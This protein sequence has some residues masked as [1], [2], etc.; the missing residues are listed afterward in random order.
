MSLAICFASG[1]LDRAPELLRV[2]INSH[3][4]D[5]EGSD[6]DRHDGYPRSPIMIM[7]LL[8]MIIMKVHTLVSFEGH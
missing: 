4:H 2:M 6:D 1:A 8:V 7:L 5:H 3:H